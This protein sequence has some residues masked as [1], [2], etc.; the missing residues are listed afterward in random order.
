V[1]SVFMML[2]AEKRDAHFCQ[3]LESEKLACVFG[4]PEYK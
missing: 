3:A 2:S 4:I 1:M